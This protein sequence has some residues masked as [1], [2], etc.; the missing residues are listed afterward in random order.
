MSGWGAV[1]SHEADRGIIRLPPP[2]SR[3][4]AFA[5]LYAVTCCLIDTNFRRPNAFS[6]DI[7]RHAVL[8]G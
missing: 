2:L 8:R 6:P 5:T 1:L 4:K 3:A 7:N